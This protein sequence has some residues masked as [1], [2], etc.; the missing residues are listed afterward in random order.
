MNENGPMGKF[1][2]FPALYNRAAAQRKGLAMSRYLTQNL[3]TIT[4]ALGRFARGIVVTG[5][6]THGLRTLQYARTLLARLA[7][8]ASACLQVVALRPAQ[9]AVAHAAWTVEH[10]GSRPLRLRASWRLVKP[11]SGARFVKF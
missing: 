2:F 9:P 8:E 11:G 3:D 4:S 1:A 7:D 6:A 10:A 5:L